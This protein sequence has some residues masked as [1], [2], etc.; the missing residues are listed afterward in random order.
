MRA[1]RGRWQQRSSDF[2][3]V[4]GEGRGG[5][6]RVSELNATP[7]PGPGMHGFNGGT[8]HYQARPEPHANPP[9]PP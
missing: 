7:P 9:Y 3:D 6:G 1:A 8:G 5:M 4:T 2:I